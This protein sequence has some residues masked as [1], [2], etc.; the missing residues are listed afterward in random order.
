MSD[1]SESVPNI[2]APEFTNEAL[3]AG[4]EL[5][6]AMDLLL[7]MDPFGDLVSLMNEA[8]LSRVELLLNE[9]SGELIGLAPEAKTRAVVEFIAAR[10]G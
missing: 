10:H 4:G 6:L 9:K 3:E 1:S 8:I 2:A 7:F 5:I